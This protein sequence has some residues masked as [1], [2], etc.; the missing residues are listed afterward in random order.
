MSMKSLLSLA[1]LSI[2]IIACDQKPPKDEEQGPK[3]L[4]NIVFIYADDL[5]Y[6]DVGAYGSTVLKTPNLD[7]LANGGVRFTNGYASSATCTPS[8]YAILTGVYP[9]REKDAKILPGTAPLI[10]GTDQMTVPKM[11]KT[12]GYHT[13]IVGK[14]HLGLGTGTGNWNERV[15]PGPNEVGFDY[16]YIMAATQDRVPTVYI[17]NGDVVGLDPSDPIEI[18]YKSNF[19]GEPTGKENPEMLKMKWH[20]GH[21][22]SIVNGIPRIG[23]MKG[24][25][26]AQWVDEDM[27]D[28]FLKRAQKYVSDHK[29][30]PFFLYYA[31]QQ[32][33]VPRTPHP[34]FVGKSGL[35]PRGDVIVEADWM[36]G[37]FIKTL[38]KEGLLENT[39]IVFSSDNG[40]VLNDGYYDDADTKIGDHTPWGPF[41][42]GKY[43]L[44]EAGTHVP[45]FTYWKGTIKPAVSDALV[46]QVDLLSSVAAL[47]ESGIR[48]KDSNEMLDVFLGKGKQGREDLVIEATSRT[49]Y[50]KGDWAMI[51]P[52][53]G[54][55]K[56]NQVKIELANAEVY[57]LYNLKDDIGEQNNLA[58]DNKEKL[59]EMIADFEAI[60]GTDYGKIQ[61]LELK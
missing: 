3:K 33:H 21:N 51:P 61:Q 2:L 20:H 47:V 27:A 53:K 40:P 50:R 8:R 9:W 38:E 52:Y 17:E 31:L 36:V 1:L 10:I 22:N 37:E 43:S 32:P 49:A 39:L 6:G 60:R 7:K 25:K 35:G 28:T 30:E 41:R 15:S 44:F 56:N 59:A 58:E 29:Y 11:L 34:R 26:A 55:A 14:W 48:G 12:K 24:G 23:Y 13:G 42:G 46:C 18:S 5:G 19:E 4:P 57:Q 16:S 54:P 45:F